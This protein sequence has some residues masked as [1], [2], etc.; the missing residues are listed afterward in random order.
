MP[1]KIVFYDSRPP[2]SGHDKNPITKALLP[3]QKKKTRKG[4]IGNGSNGAGFRP[5]FSKSPK[6]GHNNADQSD[7][8]NQRFEP[9]T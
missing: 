2:Q 3:T 7:F 6:A 9:D 8:R 1:S 5:L 4:G